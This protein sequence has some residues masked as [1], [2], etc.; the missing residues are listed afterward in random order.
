MTDRGSWSD[1]KTADP[2]QADERNF[3]KVEKLTRDGMHVDRLLYAGDNLDRARDIFAHHPAADAGAASVAAVEMKR[4]PGGETAALF[5][6]NRNSVKH[7]SKRVAVEA[8]TTV[9]I[10]PKRDGQSDDQ[11]QGTA[12]FQRALPSGE[13]PCTYHGEQAF[14]IVSKCTSLPDCRISCYYGCGPVFIGE[15]AE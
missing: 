13:L 9:L 1:E 8:S 4:P 10:K 7:F 15:N 12:H 11:C 3:Y 5:K 6:A 2:L 14:L